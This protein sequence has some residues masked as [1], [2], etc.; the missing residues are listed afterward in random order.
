MLI[1]LDDNA[2]PLRQNDLHVSACKSK[3]TA[4]RYQ[5]MEKDDYSQL[6][7]SEDPY[8]PPH[9]YQVLSISMKLVCM[10]VLFDG[11]AIAY[12]SRQNQ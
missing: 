9:T 8:R 5:V 11:C 4:R 10:Y 3:D 1:H 2:D 6:R 7:K 12:Y